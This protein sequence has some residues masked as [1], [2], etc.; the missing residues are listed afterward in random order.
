MDGIDAMRGMKEGKVAV[1][2][3]KEDCYRG[4]YRLKEDKPPLLQY[5]TSSNSKWMN[6]SRFNVDVFIN[7]EDVWN[8]KDS[9]PEFNLTFVEAF[10]AML[11]GKKVCS[12]TYPHFVQ[13]IEEGKLYYDALHNEGHRVQGSIELCEQSAMWRVVE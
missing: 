3:G 10:K 7:E 13:Y 1:Y 11:E 6:L 5:R 4:E 9:E 8:L 12:E 2:N